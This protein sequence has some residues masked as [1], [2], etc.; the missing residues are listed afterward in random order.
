[1]RTH[2]GRGCASTGGVWGWIFCGWRGEWEAVGR[3]ESA[4]AGG[5]AEGTVTLKGPCVRAQAC[6]RARVQYRRR[7]SASLWQEPYRPVGEHLRGMAIMCVSSILRPLR[8]WLSFLFKGRADRGRVGVEEGPA[9]WLHRLLLKKVLLAHGCLQCE[10]TAEVGGTP[11]QIDAVLAG[12]SLD[13]C[14]AFWVEP[15]RLAFFLQMLD[16]AMIV[17]ISIAD[18][19]ISGLRREMVRGEIVVMRLHVSSQR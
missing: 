7:S 15:L 2:G 8:K 9:G 18:A 10:M 14:R 12:Y 16:A 5:S 13:A 4:A 1:M 3:H 6:I 19:S 11:V 17:Q